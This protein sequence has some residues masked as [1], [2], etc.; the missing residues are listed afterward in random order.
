LTQDAVQH[1][2][3]TTTLSEQRRSSQKSVNSLA[4]FH[5]SSMLLCSIVHTSC[6]GSF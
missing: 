1:A 6:F 2:P 3:L 4:L 5:M